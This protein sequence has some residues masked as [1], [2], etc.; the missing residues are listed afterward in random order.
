MRNL[1]HFQTG[2]TLWIVKVIRDEQLS[3]ESE[4]KINQLRN[5]STKTGD[6]Q[7]SRGVMNNSQNCDEQL[8]NLKPQIFLKPSRYGLSHG[9]PPLPPIFAFRFFPIK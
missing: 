3:F 4:R 8:S 6:E 9:S 7:L 1:I 5:L 2:I